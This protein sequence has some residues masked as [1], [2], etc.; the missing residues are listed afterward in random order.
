MQNSAL[1]VKAVANA[2]KEPF[3]YAVGE[4]AEIYFEGKWHRGRIVEGYRFKDGVV[5][6]ETDDGR[7]LWCGE[8]RK[9]LYRPVRKEGWNAE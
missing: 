5:T 8:S 6:I 4:A 2:L 9:D 7:K 1:A 3:P